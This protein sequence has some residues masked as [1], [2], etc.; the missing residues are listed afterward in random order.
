[1]TPLPW[2]AL[3]DCTGKNHDIPRSTLA[4]AVTVLQHDPLFGPD[5]IWYDEFL[6]RVLIAQSPIREWRDDDDTRLTV[7]MQ[8]S[9]GMVTVTE[10]AVSSAVRHVAR[11]RT[12]HCV[13][14][15]LASL[16]WDGTPRIAHAFEEYWGA[17][18]SDAQPVDYLR[19]VS[20]NFFVGLVARVM[21][22]G[23]HLD[24]M[25]IFEGPQG[26]GKSKSLR[27]LGDVWYTL[28]IESVQGKD[29]FQ[30]LPGS[31]IIEI[32]ELESFSRAE[33]ERVKL[34]VASTED[35]YRASYD[36]HTK[37]RPRQS[38]FAGTTNR[39]DWG[40]DD[41]GLRR[42]WPV[43]CGAIR[44]DQMADMR[45]VWFAE[46]LAAFRDGVPWWETPVSALT[47][48]ADRQVEDPWTETVLAWCVGKANVTSAE[49][50]T[51]ALKFKEADITRVHQNRIGSIL[52]IAQWT[53]KPFRRLGVAGL[54][55]GWV[56]P[57]TVVTVSDNETVTF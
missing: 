32:G 16:T 27:I 8:Q 41:T 33:R 24:N 1:V 53:R 26:I 17:P 52:R 54:V 50:L 57:V 18:V 19:A 34:V 22:P 55:K 49:V 47:V 42:F 4:N 21:V 3:L 15:W 12:R 39:D 30:A 23:C 5:A 9:V 56:E 10:T 46:A 51:G 25:V 44:V 38:V 14:D 20:A 7:Y 43:R 13:R 31:W 35:K 45:P 2:A 6:D 11:Q 29:F 40:N 36:R 37:I 48:Q 28:A